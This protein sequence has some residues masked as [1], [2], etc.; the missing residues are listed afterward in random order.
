MRMSLRLILSLVAAVTVV[1]VL[2]ALYHVAAEDR[3]RRNELEKR[4][5]VLAESLQETVQAL[6]AKNSQDE[7]QR[8]VD[9]FGNRER[10]AGVAIFDNQG[11]PVLTTS[12]LQERLRAEL[13]A[14]GSR[15]VFRGSGRRSFLQVEQA[16]MH[17]YA[18]PLR[19][20]PQS[21]WALA[22]FHDDS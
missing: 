19:L 22:L 6:L 2:C 16:Q 21:S 1:S 13:P 20:D 3:S 4:A 11:R 10:L 15:A 8:I 7:L 14:A 5:Q 17:V 12:N 9:R 18:V